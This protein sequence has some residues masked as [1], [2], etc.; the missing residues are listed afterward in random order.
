MEYYIKNSFIVSKISNLITTLFKIM[1]FS[2]ISRFFAAVGFYY[3]ESF[4]C[5]LI[6]KYLKREAF[7]KHTFVYKIVS[8]LASKVDGVIANILTHTSTISS[9]SFFNNFFNKFRALLKNSFLF[10]KGYEFPLYFIS[11]F[12]IIDA[13]L[14]TFFSSISLLS[15][16]WDEAFMLFCYSVIIY[17]WIFHRERKTYTWTP[18]EL[19]LA[20]FFLV[21]TILLFLNTTIFSINVAGMRAVLQNMLWFFVTV[22]LL[23]SQ[24]SAKKLLY[25]MISV[26]TLV[27]CHGIFQVL[28]GVKVPSTWI[29]KTEYSITTRAFSVAGNPNALASLLVLLIPISFSLIYF[30]EDLRKKW[31]FTFTSAIMSGCL[32]LTFTRAAW[33]GLAAAII[34]FIVVRKDFKFMS[35]IALCI[36]GVAIA[37]PSVVSRL[38]YLFSPEYLG[39]SMNA[40]RIVRWAEGFQM[41]INN[42]YTGVGFGMFGGA[43]AANNKIPGN[44]YMD[45][46][47]LKIAVETGIFGLLSYLVLIYN[48]L[49]WTLRGVYRSV[50]G[51]YSILILGIFCGMIGVIIHSFNENVFEVPMLVFYFWSVAGIAMY[52]SRY[53]VN[54]R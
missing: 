25:L 23:K 30:E 33:F 10:Q 41:F 26:G 22:Q 7:Y 17:K 8:K 21:C 50:A 32:V 5:K 34:V 24:E 39:S 16:V 52:L 1:S 45:N 29:D 12:I 6:W 20:L 28:T 46:Y 15:N 38:F 49:V 18:L 14:R 53:D 4:L 27:S 3:R 9:N 19:P 47:F 13:I 43:V 44:F 42:I 11:F 51:K 36:L 54:R 31:L 37:M 48:T 40:G 2:F 35:I